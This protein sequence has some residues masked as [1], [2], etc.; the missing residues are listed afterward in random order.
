ML[1]PT[2]T[3]VNSVWWEC[4][5]CGTVEDGDA[6]YFPMIFFRAGARTFQGNTFTSFSMFLGLGFPKPMMIL[7][8]SSESAFALLTVNGL[9]PS[10]FRR[11]RFFSST[12]NRFGETTS[13][14]R[15]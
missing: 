12:V 13:C 6:L 2:L 3:G 11:M 9:K 10:R 4:E 14:S 1:L 5:E 7:K 15:R 8:K